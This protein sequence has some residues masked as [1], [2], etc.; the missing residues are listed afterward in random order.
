MNEITKNASIKQCVE[1]QCHKIKQTDRRSEY[2]PHD[3][4]SSCTYLDF[5]GVRSDRYQCETDAA[6]EADAGTSRLSRIRL[7]SAKE[8][9]QILGVNPNSV[10]TLWKKRLLDFWCIHGT[11]KTNLDAIAAFLE[12][13]RNQ[14]LHLDNDDNGKE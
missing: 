13:T 2:V 3:R 5:Q 4:K 8:A 6:M 10:Y 7:L 12:A 1:T 11:K 14:E 9:G